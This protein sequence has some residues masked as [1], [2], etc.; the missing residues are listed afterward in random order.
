ME[1]RR[2]TIA[3]FFAR[4]NAPRARL[5]FTMAGNI[6]G[7]RPT[8]T[9]TLKSAACSQL[10]VIFPLMTR[11]YKSQYNVLCSSMR[12]VRTMGTITSI[13]AIIMKV[14]FRIPRWKELSGRFLFNCF[15]IVAMKASKLV[16][17]YFGRYRTSRNR[18]YSPS[19]VLNTSAVPLPEITLVPINRMFSNSNRPP[20]NFSPFETF[21]FRNG[22]L[23]PVRL[24]RKSAA[25][26]LN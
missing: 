1:S 23:S 8:A 25:K 6:S 9:E 14:T 10:L 22:S 7:T 20:S 3:F 4:V 5:A 2:F 16:S 15:M 12:K 19:P 13:K 24:V 26:R 17:V 11:T 21:I 18:I